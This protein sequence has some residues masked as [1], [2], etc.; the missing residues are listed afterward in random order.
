MAVYQDKERKT[1]YCKFYYTD[2]NGE[3]KQRKKEGFKLKREAQG[4]S[5]APKRSES[6]RAT[7]VF[8][9]AER[10]VV[11]RQRRR[12]WFREEGQSLS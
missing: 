9:G 7:N 3:K 1:W 6:S 4:Q 8:S 12:V 5:K 11:P 2:Y 10:V